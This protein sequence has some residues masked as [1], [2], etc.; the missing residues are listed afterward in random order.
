MRSNIVLLCASAALAACVGIAPTQD[1]FRESD[2]VW[3][4]KKG[5]AS[6]SG[7]A[8]LRTVG[9]EVKFCAGRE[10]V[11]VPDTPY[12]EALAAA[13]RDGLRGQEHP[14]AYMK[15][16][17]TTVGDGFGNFE[18][19]D[20]PAGKWMVQC[21]LTW[22]VSPYQDTGGFAEA[23]FSLSEGESKRVIATGNPR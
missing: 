23:R 7:Q 5:T 18:F 20:L 10:I 6:V 14:P 9:G 4:A 2:F 11:L 19:R 12:A 13:N 15:Y 1:A 22:A 16:R 8:F 17:R 3:S 21:L